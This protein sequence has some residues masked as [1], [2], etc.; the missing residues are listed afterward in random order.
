MFDFVVESPVENQATDRAY[1]IGQQKDMMVYRF[2]SG[3]LWKKKIDL[4]L[5][6]KLELS[7][8]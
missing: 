4:I 2:V 7:D 6:D 5:K 8:N 1:R 3:K